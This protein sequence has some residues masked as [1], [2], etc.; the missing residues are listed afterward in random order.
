[1]TA[2]WK[3]IKN[4]WRRGE[5][6]W[7]NVPIGRKMKAFQAALVRWRQAPLNGEAWANA[8]FWYRELGEVEQMRVELNWKE[9]RALDDD[10][11][12]H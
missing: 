10:Q 8:A 2:M 12:K 3:R 9:R 4:W 5:I 6:E 1:M 7:L 11:G